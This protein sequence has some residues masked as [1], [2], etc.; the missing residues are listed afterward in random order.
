MFNAASEEQVQYPVIRCGNGR[1]T[2]LAK[3]L[4]VK[5]SSYIRSINKESI[6]DIQLITYACNVLPI[7]AYPASARALNLTPA[8]IV[9]TKSAWR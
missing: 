2:I 5:I 1:L 9:L 3:G 7:L 6:K 8:N 4:N